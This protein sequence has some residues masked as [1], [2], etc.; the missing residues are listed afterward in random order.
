M[1]VEPSKPEKMSKKKPK[2]QFLKESRCRDAVMIYIVK[3][4][5]LQNEELAFLA[6]VIHSPTFLVALECI[7]IEEKIDNFIF[8]NLDALEGIDPQTG[9]DE[10]TLG[11]KLV[12]WVHET[13]EE[14]RK[15]LDLD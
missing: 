10:E 3:I 14:Y 15:P 6:R 12:E 9:E 7:K 5:K 2:E 4:L 1:T 11:D 8:Y 13:L